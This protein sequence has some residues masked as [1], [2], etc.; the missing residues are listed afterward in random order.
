MQFAQPEVASSPGR[1]GSTTL[2]AARAGDAIA[3]GVLTMILGGTDVVKLARWLGQERYRGGVQDENGSRVNGHRVTVYVDGFN[4]YYGLRSS[5]ASLP[6]GQ[7]DHKVAM[8][9][10]GERVREALIRGHE[11]GAKA[12]CQREIHQVVDRSIK[13]NGEP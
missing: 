9:G 6:F 13:R 11:A 12:L 1:A 4:V 2:S 10:R 7:R 8:A 5:N 3:D